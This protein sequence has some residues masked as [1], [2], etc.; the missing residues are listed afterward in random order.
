MLG[1]WGSAKWHSC[2]LICW[3]NLCNS[4][5]EELILQLLRLPK[6]ACVAFA[7]DADVDATRQ[8]LA[9]ELHRTSEVFK[10]VNRT[11]SAE[12]LDDCFSHWPA[13]LTPNIVLRCSDNTL[14]A[15]R[16]RERSR[17]HAVACLWD[18]ITCWSFEQHKDSHNEASHGPTGSHDVWDEMWGARLCSQGTGGLWRVEVGAWRREQLLGINRNQQKIIL[19]KG[20]WIQRCYSKRL[21]SCWQ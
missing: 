15:S 3:C 17:C 21:Q 7:R 2:A 9:Q 11:L 10:T 6:W 14:T 19:K 4:C 13:G 18:V 8:W 20:H 1:F 12:L 16:E 5:S